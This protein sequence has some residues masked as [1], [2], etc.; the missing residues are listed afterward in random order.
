MTE[1]LP[2]A[3]VAG[4]DLN[5]LGVVRALGGAGIPV[6]ALDTNLKKPTAATRYCAKLAVHALSGPEFIDE[7]LALRRRFAKKPVLL[8]TQEA[9]VVTVSAMRERLAEAYC[10]T[11]PPHPLMEVLLDKV[12]F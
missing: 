7:L 6:V 2:P 4:L 8:L 5:G 9:S 11:L 1:L 10:F 12:R 3:I